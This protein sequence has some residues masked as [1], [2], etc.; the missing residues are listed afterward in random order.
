MCKN[1]FQ[2]NKT[3]LFVCLVFCLLTF[4]KTVNAET[5]HDTYIVVI[6]DYGRPLGFIDEKNNQISGFS[7]DIMT[8][9]GKLSGLRFEYV[10]AKNYDDLLKLFLDNKADI[11]PSIA[12]S[13][14][15]KR[16]FVF[17][18]PY[19]S[20]PLL[21]FVKAS[22]DSISGIIP[23]I[24]VGAVKASAA[25]R[26]LM[27]HKDIELKQYS[28]YQEVHM[29]LLKKEIDAYCAS[30]ARVSGLL[31]ET[32]THGSVKSVGEP[33]GV[34]NRAIAIRKDKAWL[35]GIIDDAV[36]KLINSPNYKGI[37]KKWYPEELQ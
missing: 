3:W 36:N 5:K 30:A 8:E 19:E 32:N 26:Y 18:K 6:Q 34:V 14:E 12:I 22:E 4:S 31:K 33:V 20:T 28:T 29:A 10:F 15:R 27:A 35:L 37:R 9:I 1:R 16:H 25:V 7:F 24:K 17:S 13:E 11:T 2:Q 23:K 21:L